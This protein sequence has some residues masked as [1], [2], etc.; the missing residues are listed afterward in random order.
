MHCRIIIFLVNK[1]EYVSGEEMLS[2]N[3][4]KI[5]EQA[6]YTY[7]ILEK[8]FEKQTKTIE[9]HGIPKN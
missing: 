1:H 4:K 8:A 5:I 3:Q 9:D 2:F 6:K 7:S